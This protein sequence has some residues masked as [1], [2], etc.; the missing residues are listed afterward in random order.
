MENFN[1]NIQV[2]CI[3]AKYMLK[4]KSTSMAWSNDLHQKHR[5][6]NFYYAS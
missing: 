1:S 2:V 6:W 4:H 3:I 5:K